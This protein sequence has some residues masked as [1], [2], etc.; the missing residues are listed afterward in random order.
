MKINLIPK[1]ISIFMLFVSGCSFA[2]GMHMTTDS[3][4]LDDNQTVYIESIDKDIPIININNT[5]KAKKSNIYKY[6]IGTGDQIAITVWGLQDIFPL[7]GINTELNLRRVDENGN[8]FFPYAGL[9]KASGKTQD[10]L[11]QKS[12]VRV[13]ISLFISLPKKCISFKVANC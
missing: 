3:T 13:I 2:P 9:V 7:S 1:V 6:E 5:F 4:W 8:I 10:E 11:R 12:K